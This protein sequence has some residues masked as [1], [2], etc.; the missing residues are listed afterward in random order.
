MVDTEARTDPSFP[1]HQS[2]TAKG[3]RWRSSGCRNHDGAWRQGTKHPHGNDISSELLLGTWW[4]L[5]E[6]EDTWSLLP[7]MSEGNRSWCDT[8]TKI[9]ILSPTSVILF[10]I[11]PGTYPNNFKLS[12]LL[13]MTLMLEHFFPKPAVS[14]GLPK[15]FLCNLIDLNQLCPS[16]ASK[17]VVMEYVWWQSSLT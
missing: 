7:H 17:Q 8:R 2:A 14:E 6:G 16:C 1:I 3:W 5:W 12:C 11:C 4:L 10:Y 9:T 13:G 15:I